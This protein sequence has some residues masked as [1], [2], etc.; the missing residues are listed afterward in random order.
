MLKRWGVPLPSAGTLQVFVTRGA[1]LA[2]L[3]VAALKGLSD[4]DRLVLENAVDDR[5]VVEP[6]DLV[7]HAAGL[8]QGVHL[9]G[10]QVEDR[11]SPSHHGARKP[12]FEGDLACCRAT[13]MGT[14]RWSR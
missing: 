10:G 7:V 9:E 5:G 6:L 14:R 13:A 1:P 3:G 4:G 8:G 12:P 11:Q 2:M